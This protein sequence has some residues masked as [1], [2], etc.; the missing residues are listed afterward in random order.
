MAG[1]RISDL[2]VATTLDNNDLFV[3]ARGNSNRKITGASLL[4]RANEV[5][6]RVTSL[7]ATCDAK[8]VLKAGDTMSGFLTL[9]ANPTNNSHA[10]TKQ[11]V[12]QFAV[13][14]G[15]VLP[16]ATLTIPD[17]WLICDGTVL[18]AGVGTIQSKTANFL[19]LYNLLRASFGSAGKLPD[20]RGMFVRGHGAGA[21]GDSTGN[22]GRYQS[23]A[24]LSHAHSGNTGTESATHTHNSAGIRGAH[25]A[26]GSGHAVSMLY[27]HGNTATDGQSTAHYH[28][29]TTSTVGG[30]EARP[31]NV[32]LLYCIKY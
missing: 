7:S 10:A 17:G 18:P 11:Y 28:G 31:R 15:I 20:L 4:T 29:F 8:F 32:S 26:Y 5:N 2:S 6:S 16:F 25:A 1:V 13:P 24:N 27:G 12:D 21:N 19:T 22:I 14:T 9:H 23:D 3:V 30:T